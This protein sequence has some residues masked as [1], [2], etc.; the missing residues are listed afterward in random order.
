VRIDPGERDELLT[1]RGARPATM[2]ADRDMGARWLTV[3]HGALD[4]DDELASWLEAALRQH[5]GTT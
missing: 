4:A 2:G 1:R 5:R 3:G